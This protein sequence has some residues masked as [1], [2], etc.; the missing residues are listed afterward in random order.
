MHD[1]CRAQGVYNSGG[2]IKHNCASKPL[3][4]AIHA[5]RA[6]AQ[7]HQGTSPC[8]AQASMNALYLIQKIQFL[9][10]EYSKL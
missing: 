6:M 7:I 2:D 5:R 3:L 1:S 9:V 8:A 4:N 10:G